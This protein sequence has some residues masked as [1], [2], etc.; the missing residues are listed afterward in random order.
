MSIP[1]LNAPALDRYRPL[2]DDW[3][4]FLDALRRPLPTAIWT[5]TLRA[6]P[7]EVAALLAH[8][9]IP[10]EPIPWYP[11]AFRLPPDLNP[12]ATMAYTMGLYHVQEEVSLLPPV[13]LD[14]QP[15]E[16]VID[17]CAAPGNKTAQIAVAMQNRGTVVAN[18]VSGGRMNVTRTTLARLGLANVST[19][20]VN[21]VQYPVAEPFDRVL[22]DVPC[23]CEGTS[24]KHPDVLM[25][26]NV[27]RSCTLGERQLAILERGLRLCRPGGRIVYA[28]CTY[29]PEENE[30]VLDALLR[31]HPDAVRLL[32]ARIDGVD[33]S[34]GLTAWGGQAL[35]P[36]LHRALRVWPHQLDS[37]GFFVAVLEKT[38]AEA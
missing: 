20:H 23:S 24:R 12:G 35:H 16:R 36:D 28:T 33:A 21:A 38:K 37:G 7:E 6:T 5:N 2:V 14:P 10:V 11:G 13:L 30:R 3:D 22:A 8:E 29:A 1:L 31:S 26:A 19:T 25:R 32:P 9:G 18:D 4:A 34:P 15:G 17:L 27:R